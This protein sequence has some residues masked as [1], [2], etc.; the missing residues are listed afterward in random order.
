VLTGPTPVQGDLTPKTDGLPDD[1]R[2]Q[3]RRG[4]GKTAAEKRRDARQRAL[5]RRALRVQGERGQ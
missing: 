3:D 4:A 5:Q 2:I 1:A